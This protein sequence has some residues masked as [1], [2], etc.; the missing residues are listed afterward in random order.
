VI[1]AHRKISTRVALV[2][3]AMAKSGQTVLVGYRTAPLSIVRLTGA[4]ML[5]FSG[6]SP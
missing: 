5:A 2:L 1:I 3:R 4:V 6:P